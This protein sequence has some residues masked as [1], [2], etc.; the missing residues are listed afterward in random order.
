MVI[1]VRIHVFRQGQGIEVPPKAVHQFR[2]ESSAEV[3]F[4]VISAPKSHGGR[5]EVAHVAETHTNG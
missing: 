3:V 2:N 4:L 1:D 5:V